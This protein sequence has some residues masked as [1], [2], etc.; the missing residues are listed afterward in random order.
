MID[1]NNVCLIGRLIRDSELKY[2]T[3]GQAVSK[4]S[5][6]VDR[7]VKDGGIWKTEANFFDVT[8]WGKMAESLNQYLTKGKQVAIDGELRQD[9]WQQDG[10][11]RSKVEVVAHTVQ[12]LGGG[13]ERGQSAQPQQALAS[14][15][16]FTNDIPF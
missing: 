14:D 1:L 15:D 4:F 11:N 16:G 5:L 2:T 6:A 10:V 7:R 13:G 8:L 3:S 9:R 12:L